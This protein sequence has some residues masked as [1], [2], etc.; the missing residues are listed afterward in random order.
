MN[1]SSNWSNAWERLFRR[2]A[3]EPK[4]TPHLSRFLVTSESAPTEEPSAIVTRGRIT[5]PEPIITWRSNV[6]FPL[7]IPVY[8][9]GTVGVCQKFSRIIVCPAVDSHTLWKTREVFHH[10][11]VTCWKHTIPTYMYKRT[12]FNISAS[13]SNDRT[14]TI[15]VNS[16]IITNQYIFNTDDCAIFRNRYIIA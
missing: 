3:G 2:L 9:S 8:F 5:E 13:G 10:N 15:T 16:Y 7:V 11:A 4:Y 6:T 14:G 1:C 12:Q